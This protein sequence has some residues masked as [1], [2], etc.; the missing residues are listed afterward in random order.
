MSLRR[1]LVLVSA[2]AVGVAILLAAVVSYVAVRG[3]LRGQVDDALNAQVDRVR[4]IAPLRPGLEQGPRPS[5]PLPAPPPREGGPAPYVQF[6]SPG[7]VVHP[8][9]DSAARLPVGAAERSVAERG[10]GRLLE[11]T[12]VGGDHLRVLTVPVEGVGALQL[13]RSLE[14]TDHVLARL[15]LLLVLLVLAGTAL[16][17]LLARLATRTVLTPITQ[18][19]EA[20][21]HISMTDD[22]RRRIPATGS[23]EVG[24]LAAR[25]N[26]MLD[27]LE[28]S[29]AALGDSVEAQ[30]QLVADASHELRTPVTSLRTN[31]EVLIGRGELP[32]AERERLLADVLQQTEELSALIADLIDLARGEQPPAEVEDVR[33]DELAE[34][35]IERARRFTRDVRFETDLSPST[36]QATPERLAR[37]VN[38]LLDNAVKHSPADGVVEVR[39]ADGELTVRDHGPGVPAGEAEHVFDRFYRGD[40]AR[41]RPG[42]GLGLAIVRQVAETHGGQV[43]VENAHGGGALFTL[44]LLEARAS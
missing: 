24:R 15:R 39:V 34:E 37:A 6:I 40:G 30:R 26:A 11:D 9:P 7:G 25:F 23:D 3:E 1:R 16:V 42:S 28:A 20:A 4:R 10:T 44:R 33:L 27:T 18:L 22:L 35:A 8:A 31:I 36:V 12:E 38:N 13:G 14:S 19:S 32:P 41:G 5:M 29:R 43:S 17:A 21:E 2:A